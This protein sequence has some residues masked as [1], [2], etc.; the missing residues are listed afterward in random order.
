MTRKVRDQP[1]TTQEELVND[2]KAVG[3]TVR[4]R[5]ISNT[6]HHEG[7]KSSGSSAEEGTC[8]GPSEVCQITP[9]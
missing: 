6:L 8:R 1:S 9:G 3:A 5:T 4:K 7:L 2:L